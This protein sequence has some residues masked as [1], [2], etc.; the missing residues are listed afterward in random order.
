MGCFSTTCNSA[1]DRPHEQPRMGPHHQTIPPTPHDTTTHH[2]IFD[3]PFSHVA[4]QT[5]RREDRCGAS[6]PHAYP[7]AEQ[8]HISFK[9]YP[10]K[11][12]DQ[13]TA[14]LHEVMDLAFDLCEHNLPDALISKISTNS[15]PAGQ[16]AT[17]KTFSR[18]PRQPAN[19]Y[20][21]T[22]GMAW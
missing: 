2:P 14:Q 12:Q 1:M 11:Q 21:T 17:S 13:Y 8:E 15:W 10:R 16:V 5:Q 9:Q 7:A 22:Q 20:N 4:C 3:Q 18:T 19:R 6:A